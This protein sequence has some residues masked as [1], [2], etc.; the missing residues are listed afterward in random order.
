MFKPFEYWEADRTE[1]ERRGGLVY[2]T[3]RSAE[4]IRRRLFTI[5]DLRTEYRNI[6]AVL[7]AF[8][9][10][11]RGVVAEIRAAAIH[12]PDPSPDL[13]PGS[14]RRGTVPGRNARPR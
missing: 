4:A 7:D 3:L 9:A 5:A 6:G 2:T 10:E 12:S 14:T 8:D 11:Q 13:G 1:Y